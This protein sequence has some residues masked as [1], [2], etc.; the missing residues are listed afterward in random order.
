MSIHTVEGCTNIFIQYQNICQYVFFRCY[1]E[2]L[3]ECDSKFLI[4]AHH[5][6]VLDA[7]EETVKAK[8]GLINL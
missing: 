2:D 5:G 8:V 7:I 4:F 6:D 1:I 3:L